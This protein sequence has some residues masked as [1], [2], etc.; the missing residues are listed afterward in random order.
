M[1]TITSSLGKSIYMPYV[2]NLIEVRSIV[3]QKQKQK[4][5]YL[6]ADG[7]THQPQ[8]DPASL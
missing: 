2:L 1:I 8:Y 3:L 6:Q 4:S 7:N 5:L